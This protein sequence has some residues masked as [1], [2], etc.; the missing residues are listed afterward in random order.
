MDSVNPKHYKEAYPFEV[1]EM[2]EKMLT[3]EQFVGYCLGNEIK[4]RMRAGFK[5]S[6][7]VEEIKKAEWYN[8]RRVQFIFEKDLVYGNCAN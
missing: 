8:N 3:P 1:I 7:V 4:Y 5:H 2:I 6:D